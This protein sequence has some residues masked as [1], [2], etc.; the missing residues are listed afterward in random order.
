MVCLDSPKV[1]F[2]LGKDSFLI[3]FLV[4]IGKKILGKVSFTSPPNSKI[5][6]KALVLFCILGSVEVPRFPLKEKSKIS[7]P[8]NKFLKVIPVNPE[9]PNC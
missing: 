6:K 8:L 7:A 9:I 5:L 4:L 2:V 1:I 3:I